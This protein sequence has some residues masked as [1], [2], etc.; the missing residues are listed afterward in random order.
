LLVL[1]QVLDVFNVV[2]VKLL[3]IFI[4]SGYVFG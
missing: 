3:Y 4:D 2:F 1:L